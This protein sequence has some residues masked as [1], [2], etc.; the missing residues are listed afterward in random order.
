MYFVGHTPQINLQQGI[1]FLI[2]SIIQDG[3]HAHTYTLQKIYVI[4]YF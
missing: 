1:C 2:A 4:N 3:L